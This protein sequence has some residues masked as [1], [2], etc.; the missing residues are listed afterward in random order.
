M[1]SEDERLK[2]RMINTFKDRMFMSKDL[3]TKVTI[4]GEDVKR[5]PEG[6]SWP[7]MFFDVTKGTQ[8]QRTTFGVKMYEMYERYRLVDEEEAKNIIPSLP[9]ATVEVGW[10]KRNMTAMEVNELQ[11]KVGTLRRMYVERL[12]SS[13]EWMD[14]TDEERIAEL[15]SIYRDAS[16]KV[17]SEMFMLDIVKASDK[18]EFLRANDFIPVPTSSITINGK[19]ITGEEAADFYD[20]VQ[21]LFVLELG[22]MPDG[23]VSEDMREDYKKDVEKAWARAKKDVTGEWRDKIPEPM[24]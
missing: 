22:G 13:E 18:W 4:W 10:D 3:P 15:Q 12:M 14:M 23:R 7:Y 21:R 9:S 5:I 1:Y 20:Q 19:R 11:K 24:E 16:T 2:R 17:K 8:Y 6:R